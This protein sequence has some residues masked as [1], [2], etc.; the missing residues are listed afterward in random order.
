VN[1][2]QLATALVLALLLALGWWYRP[3]PQLPGA[4]YDGRDRREAFAESI[5]LQ[6]MDNG[7]QPVYQLRASSM[8]YYPGEDRLT[9]QQPRLSLAHTDGSRWEMRAEQGQTGLHSTAVLLI[10]MVNIQRLEVNSYKPL[11]VNTRD[12][13]VKTD[14]GQAETE[15]AASIAGPGYRVE[16]IGLKAD[17]KN[18]RLELGAQVRGRYDAAG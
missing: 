14:S 1:G 5:H 18:Q 16:A 3:G 2:R 7:G 11:E 9:L 6:V 8:D 4:G 17:L 13:L 10:G 15:S 12:L